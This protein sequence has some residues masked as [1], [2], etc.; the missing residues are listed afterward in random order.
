MGLR[1]EI[2]SQID[3]RRGELIELCA[4]C[5]RI[6]GITPSGDTTRISAFARDQLERSGLKTTIFEPR[7]GSPNVVAT[8]GQPEATPNLVVNA[9]LDTF[10]PA[11]GAWTHGDPFS[12]ALVEDRIFGC[13]ASDMRGS[14]GATLF[15]LGLLAG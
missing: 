3:A 10:P 2:W 14:L 12:G 5:V 1:E 6:A 7:P 8:L 9:H 13:G 11:Q 4:G 15:V